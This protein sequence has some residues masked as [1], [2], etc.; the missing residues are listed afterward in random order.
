MEIAT[1]S[2]IGGRD[3]NEDYALTEMKSDI[4]GCC[5]VADGLGG[6]RFGEEASS[7][8]AEAFAEEFRSRGECSARCLNELFETAQ[9][10]LLK[11]TEEPGHQGM[12][13]T[14]TALIVQGNNAIWGHIGD[15]RLYLFRDGK[16]ERVTADHSV[17]YISYLNGEISYDE[18]RRSPDQNRLIRS[19]G[20]PDKFKPELLE[21]PIPI[22][23]GDAFL[24]CTD[25]FWEYISEKEMLQALKKSATASRWLAKMARTIKKNASK[26]PDRDNCTA[27]TVFI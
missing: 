4:I 20:S 13:T 14:F 16:V 26:E 11:R 19:L 24:L 10:T 8:A 27:I 25:G 6:H 12:R 22:E 15:S 9:E 7:C 21:Q 5:V 17:A 2:E 1:M 18:I 3:I 23:D